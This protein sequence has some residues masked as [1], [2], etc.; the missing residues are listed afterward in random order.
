MKIK[1]VIVDDEA[2]ARRRI[3]SLLAKHEEFELVGEADSGNQAIDL[4]NAI[5]P[6]FLI[7]DIQLKDMTGF[8]VLKQIQAVAMEVV[9]ITAYDK[10]AIRAFEKGAVDYLLKPYKVHRFEDALKRIIKRFKDGEVSL[11]KGMYSKLLAISDKKPVI[12]VNEGKT[13]HFIDYTS[14]IYIQ[15]DG[16]HC[17]FVSDSEPK[18]MIRVSLKEM[19]N[20]LPDTFKRV[21][22]S[23]IL[24]LEKV[25]SYRKLKNS[26][27]IELK[28]A[29]TFSFSG[30]KAD[31]L[32]RNIVNK[33]SER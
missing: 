3:K 9:F 33:V 28:G 10:F 16:Y 22:R 8:D 30:T 31:K 17:N 4:I 29:G 14:L 21:G 25:K 24:N 12:E 23:Y 5:Q 18:K 13:T 2:P 11:I 1:T 7:L 26:I 32:Y 15:A 27:D 20:I 19:E 6:D